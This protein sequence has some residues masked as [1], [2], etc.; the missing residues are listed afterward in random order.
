M[1][2]RVYCP[3]CENMVHP[4]DPHSCFSAAAHREYRE[5]EEAVIKAAKALRDSTTNRQMVVANGRLEDAVDVLRELE[6]DA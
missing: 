6:G 2:D 5:A 3:T 1:T 4:T